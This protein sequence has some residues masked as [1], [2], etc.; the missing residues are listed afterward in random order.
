MRDVIHQRLPERE[1]CSE[2]I[3]AEKVFHIAELFFP[4]FSEKCGNVTYEIQRNEISSRIV[5]SSSVHIRNTQQYFQLKV[6]L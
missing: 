1:K 5:F 6:F 2:E 3:A 4:C